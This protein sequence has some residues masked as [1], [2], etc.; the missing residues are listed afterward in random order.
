MKIYYI[1]LLIF[2]TWNCNSNKVKKDNVVKQELEKSYDSKYAKFNQHGDF[3][4]L[5]NYDHVLNE[6]VNDRNGI[7]YIKYNYNS[8]NLLESIC[9]FDNE[10]KPKKLACKV[11][12][13][14]NKGNIITQYLTRS[15]DDSTYGNVNYFYNA[16][17]QL[18]KIIREGAKSRI[19]IDGVGQIKYSYDSQNRITKEE[20]FNCD[21]EIATTGEMG[22]R[23]IT[24]KYNSEGNLIE[25]IYHYTGVVNPD[26]EPK[27]KWVN[28][29]H[30]ENKQLK[31]SRYKFD[32]NSEKYDYI[33]YFKID[34]S[35]KLYGMNEDSN[36]IILNLPFQNINE[37]VLQELYSGD[38]NSKIIKYERF[39]N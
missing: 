32:I 24:Y 39:R 36:K 21:G 1:I 16:R 18:T 35:S 23:Y 34:D 8:D 33:N 31:M 6:V 38:Y 3:L 13:Y 10:M 28:E 20:Y 9:F 2:F 30:Y 22:I 15:S 25:E 4:V 19:S 37:I 29:Y 5:Q 12:E 7:A 17:N 27:Y 11:F 26:A 14:N